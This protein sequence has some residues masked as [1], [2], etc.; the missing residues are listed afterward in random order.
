MAEIKN[1]T[2][3]GK[4]SKMDTLAI[5]KAIEE[6]IKKSAHSPLGH[7]T[8]ATGVATRKA[9]IALA[10]TT[11]GVVVAAAA[12]ATTTTTTTAAAAGG[13]GGIGVNSDRNSAFILEAL[14]AQ[15]NA[16]IQAQKVNTE[17]LTH[18]IVGALNNKKAS[19]GG[20]NI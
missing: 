2:R 3:E 20:V 12:V 7:V 15:T 5:I 16:I 4:L 1:Y 11:S 17:N 19:S 18:A 6:S 9:S 14:N 8:G 10:H 13:G